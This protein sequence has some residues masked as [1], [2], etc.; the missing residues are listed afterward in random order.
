MTSRVE[1]SV[2]ESRRHF[3]NFLQPL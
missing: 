1:M 3:W 2:D